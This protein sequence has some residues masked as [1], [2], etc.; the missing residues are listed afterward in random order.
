MSNFTGI[1]DDDINSIIGNKNI[2]S[3][4]R[5]I[6]NQERGSNDNLV[7]FDEIQTQ[8]L[9]INK[10]DINNVTYCHD[11]GYSYKKSMKVN[12][13]FLQYTEDRNINFS[14]DRYHVIGA[15]DGHGGSPKMSILASGSF[16]IYFTKNV[17][18]LPTIEKALL[19]TFE[20]INNLAKTKGGISGTT[21]TVCVI[22]NIIK[23]AYIANLGDSVIQIFRRND[24]TFESVFR[25]VDHDANNLNEQARLKEKFGNRVSFNYADKTKAGSLYAK[26]YND[27]IMVVGGIGDFQFPEGFI[28]RIPD[29]NT[30]D[31]QN[32]DVIICSSDGFYESFNKSANILC[33]C[34][35]EQEIITDLNELYIS[36]KI[37]DSPTL[38]FDL[39][40]RHI[41]K[42][43][44]L[45][46][47]NPDTVNIVKTY[48]D[49]NTIITFTVK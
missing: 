23:R 43:A 26:I 29:I 42:I 14:F 33:A 2:V 48:R 21:L 44:E 4:Q 36:D 28:R 7:I 35:N 18:N 6:S 46:D 30:V 10:K 31:L 11:P 49:N 37:Y 13:K 34:R 32:G 5:S 39:M 19:Q 47:G 41:H 38:A 20:D 25:T 24:I 27:E 3:L 17:K 45:I 12:G 16:L 8:F 1:V 15:T 40:E 22:D 9:A